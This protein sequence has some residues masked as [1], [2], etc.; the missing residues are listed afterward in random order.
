MNWDEYF[1]GM[2][3][4]IASKSKDSST[5][6][7]ALIAYPDHGICSTGFN[8]FARGVYD[9]P[10]TGL[11][12]IVQQQVQGV[13][14]EEIEA[15]LTNRETKLKLTVHAEPNAI[16]NAAKHGHCTAGCTIYVNRPPCSPC[17]AAII[18]AGIVR[19]V[20][21][22][23]EDYAKRWGADTAL[24]LQQF[25]ERGIEVVEYKEESDVAQGACCA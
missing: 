23:N 19:V 7:A 16:I 11:E 8:G 22:H 10:S 2:L 24:T 20:F 4:Y 18:Q 3:P 9:A 13:S 1:L 14:D 15:R 6:C 12:S 25:K 21:R 5:K 17:A